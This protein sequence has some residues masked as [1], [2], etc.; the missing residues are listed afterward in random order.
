MK[1]FIFASLLF[2]TMSTVTFAQDDIYFTPTKKDKQAA[3]EYKLQQQK[4]QQENACSGCNRDVDEYN[5]RGKFR[6]QYSVI[7]SDS[8]SNDVIDFVA[9]MPSDSTAYYGGEGYSGYNGDDDYAYSRRMSRF[10]DFYWYDPWYWSS[11]YSPWGYAS[12]YW[13]ARYGWGWYDPWY[14]PWYYGWGWGHPYYGY[15]WGWGGWYYPS[16]R[17][18]IAYGN[19]S[20]RYS[21]TNNH[22][23]RGLSNQKFAQ[24]NGVNRN[25]SNRSGVRNSTY[26]DNNGFTNRMDNNTY[27]RP[28]Y[29][30]GSSFGSSRGTFGGGGSFGGT[31]RGGSFGGG[32]G[33]GGHFGGGRR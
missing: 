28:S 1:K 24:R 33:G 14:D 18:V 26:R 6:S 21:G 23:L 9:G 5:R 31:R 3:K 20:W 4:L 27:S 22:G 11:W 7:G 30:N 13:Y 10:D 16:Y 32:H 15:G 2:G 29:N 12:P 17:P 8:T 25:Y 19:G